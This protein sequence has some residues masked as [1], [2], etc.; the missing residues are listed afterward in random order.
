[1]K[2]DIQIQIGERMAEAILAERVELTT[3]RCGMPAKLTFTA[4]AE[5]LEDAQEGGCVLLT[6]DGTRMFQGYVFTISDGGDGRLK[7]TAYDQLRYLKNHDSYAFP[8]ATAGQIVGMIGE[9]YSMRLGEISD[10]GHVISAHVED[11]VGLLDMIQSAIDLTLGATREL[12][13][14]YDE[15]GRLTLKNV[16]EM[17]WGTVIDADCCTAYSHL[18]SIDSLCYNRVKLVCEDAEDGRR[19]FISGDAEN[20][21]RWGTLQYFERI[22]E[23]GGGQARADAL[24]ALY[25]AKARSLRVNLAFADAGLR[26]GCLV[27]VQLKTGRGEICE[28]MLVEKCRQVFEKGGG[29]AEL[30]LRGI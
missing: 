12:Y 25:N 29:S 20:Q 23:A 28:R 16:R 2:I 30:T 26:A 22:G 9:D 13:V 10:T 19:L 21:D 1:M 15:G 18:S 7:F 6:L 27:P 14:L 11:N 17:Q 24:L 4:L 3:E 5:G 8:D